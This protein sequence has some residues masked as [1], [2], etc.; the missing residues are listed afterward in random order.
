MIVRERVPR[1]R[2]SPRVPP[3]VVPGRARPG[4]FPV[5]FIPGGFPVEGGVREPL[6]EQ[7]G[8]RRGFRGRVDGGLGPLHGEGRLLAVASGVYLL[9]CRTLDVKAEAAAAERADAGLDPGV[10]GDE[11]ALDNV[12]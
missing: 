9:A 2:A 4:G 11:L 6:D 3:R 1:A 10:P 12:D 5:G 8:R 7:R